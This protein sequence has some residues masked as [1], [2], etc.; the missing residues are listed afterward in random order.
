M[1]V[2]WARCKRNEAFKRE[3][4]LDGRR[5]VTGHIVQCSLTHQTFQDF[6]SDGLLELILILLFQETPH[7]A[8]NR[9]L[10]PDRAIAGMTL[11]PPVLLT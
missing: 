8:L 5:A 1:P 6:L 9:M 10:R 2:T 7:R 11:P 3:L 4:L